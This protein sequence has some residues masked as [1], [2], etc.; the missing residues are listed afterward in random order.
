[1][2]QASCLPCR[3]SMTQATSMY[4]AI[5][6][7]H[8][9]QLTKVWEERNVAQNIKWLD[10]EVITPF[11]THWPEPDRIIPLTTRKLRNVEQNKT[12]KQILGEQ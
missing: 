3:D 6:L 1:M 12:K 7:I 9:L 5:I 2:L 10:P 11:L 8:G 4:D